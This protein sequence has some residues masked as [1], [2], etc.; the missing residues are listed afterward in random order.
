MLAT[1]ER[2]AETLAVRWE[3]VSLETGDVD[4]NQQIQRI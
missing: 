3:N 4:C 2:I 1:S